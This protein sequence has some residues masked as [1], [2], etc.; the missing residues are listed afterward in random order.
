MKHYAFLSLLFISNISFAE[1]YVCTS[2]GAVGI[3]DFKPKIYT[4]SQTRLVSLDS[5]TVKSEYLLG[6]HENC[7]EI[8]FFFRCKTGS[9]HFSMSKETLRFIEHDRNAGPIVEGSHLI[10]SI[11]IGTC[12]KF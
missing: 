12:I 10:P 4:G 2:E 3:Q 8:S 6:N 5:M 9:R 11:E 1:T 7:E